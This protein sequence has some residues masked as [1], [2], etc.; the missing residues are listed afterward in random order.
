[1]KETRC[2]RCGMT[3]E[4]FRRTGLLGCANCYPYFREELAPV[5]RRV[6]GRT[7]HTGK[8]PQE[9]DGGYTILLERQIL[10]EGIERA[11]REKRYA[12]A[13][14]LQRQLETFTRED[15]E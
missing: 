14:K 3:L 11:L 1:M 15:E 4:E 13:E 2:P 5:L 8:I 10:K 6:Q 7:V 12:D 9:P